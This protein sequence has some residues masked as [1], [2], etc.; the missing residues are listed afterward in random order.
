MTKITGFDTFDIRFPTSR[1]LAGSDAMNPA[2]DYSAAYV[3]IR[4]DAA[5]PALSGHGFA[6]TIGRGNDVQLA[7]IRLAALCERAVAEGF[8]Q[9]K[10]KVGAAAGRRDRRDAGPGLASSGMP[11]PSTASRWPRPR[12]VS[13]C[14]TRR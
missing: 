8:G 10:I 12:C 1:T 3:V 6:F 7:A 4:T 13:P 2:P 5:D 9:V 11:A 14:A